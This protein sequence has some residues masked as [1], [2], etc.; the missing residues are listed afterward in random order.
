M[1]S[2]FTW[3]LIREVIMDEFFEG[4]G[5]IVVVIIVIAWFFGSVAGLVCYFGG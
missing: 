5:A 2:W 4:V 3:S 1:A